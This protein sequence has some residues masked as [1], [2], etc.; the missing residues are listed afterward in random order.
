MGNQTKIAEA[1]ITYAADIL[2]DTNNGLSGKEIVSLCAQHAV[3]HEIHIP[4]PSNSVTNLPSKRIVLRKNLE[5]FTPVQQYSL[6]QALCK[7]L[8]NK[9]PDYA[10]VQTLLGKLVAQ[11]SALEQNEIDNS[12]F[13]EE[14]KDWLDK[15]PEIQKHYQSALFKRNNNLFTRNLLDD[16]RF[17]LELLFKEILNN[18][19]SLEKQQSDL[20][21]F[22][23]KK[24]ISKEVKNLYTNV[25]LN[26]YNKYQNENVKHNENFKA[27]EVDFIIEQTT[28]LMRLLLKA[29]NEK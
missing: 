10:E 13:I 23:E 7:E 1:F 20:G 17:S 21:L 19:K 3:K 8:H 27:I 12:E 5:V 4:Y 14:T 22:L 15:Y 29:H 24:N 26:F 16:L 9:N 25:L 6:I 18:S 2:G 11:Y 28:A